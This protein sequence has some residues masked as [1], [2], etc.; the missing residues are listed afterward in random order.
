M[1][2]NE[3]FYPVPQTLVTKYGA[4]SAE[5][6][7]WIELI[8]G[9]DRQRETAYSIRELCARWRWSPRRSLAFVAELVD[10][11]WVTQRKHNRK[12]STLDFLR[13]YGESGNAKGNTTTTPRARSQS[14]NLEEN[15]D[16][17][18]QNPPDESFKTFWTAYPR[19]VAKPAAEKAWNRIKPSGEQLQIMLRVLA[20]QKSSDDWLKE[21]GKYIPHPATWI[22][23]R[24]WEDQIPAMAQPGERRFQ[25]P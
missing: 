14:L 1:G 22:N 6:S 5:V 7:A 9:A 23:Q 17:V 20:V 3:P 15:T 25:P 2:I 13:F 11:G 21:D 18:I 19:K 24:R 16:T 4:D 8:A 12:R 10:Q